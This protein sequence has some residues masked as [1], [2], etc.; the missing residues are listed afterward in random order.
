[1]SIAYLNSGA[2]ELPNVRMVRPQRLV[3]GDEGR[4]AGGKLRRDVVAVKRSWTL[5]CA[6]LTQTQY[7]AI[8]GYLDGI[9]FAAT[10]FWLDELGGAA[11]TDSIAAYVNIDADDR[12]QFGDATGFH[13]DGHS[14]VLIIREQ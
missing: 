7:D 1:M 14:I 13:G 10:T 2:V 8:V 6:F 4:T 5:E 9:L 3:I 11:A 12:V